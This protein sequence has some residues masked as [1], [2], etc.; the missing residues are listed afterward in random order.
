MIL[1]H[2]R[3]SFSNAE[4]IAAGIASKLRAGGTSFYAPNL[5]SISLL[6]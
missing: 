6:L 4:Y 5:L 2:P 3:L 1:V